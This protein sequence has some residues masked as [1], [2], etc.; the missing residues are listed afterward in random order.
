MQGDKTE[1]NRLTT[2]KRTE[3]AGSEQPT[4]RSE[5]TRS[6]TPM[7]KSA[8]TG[9]EGANLPVPT[10]VVPTASEFQL[11]EAWKKGYRSW[12]LK[13]NKGQAMIKSAV[14]TTIRLE[15]D[16]MFCAGDMC[17]G[18]LDHQKVPTLE[19]KRRI[20]Q[21]IYT[22]KMRGNASADQMVKYRQLCAVD[23]GYEGS[24]LGDRRTGTV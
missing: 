17:K 2:V 11:V 16:D 7:T 22:M 9:I 19:N 3:R 1:P 18:C 14:S 4:L 5:P 6:A 24:R 20:D 21:K 13:E 12:S 10:V 15:I 8:S 23:V